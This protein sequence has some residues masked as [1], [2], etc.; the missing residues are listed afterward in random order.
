MKSHFSSI[1][2]S[3]GLSLFTKSFFSKERKI[4]RFKLAKA[5]MNNGT[6]QQS[7]KKTSTLVERRVWRESGEDKV[8]R[9]S[10]TK[11]RSKAKA[12]NEDPERKD[13]DSMERKGR[14]TWKV[15]LGDLAGRVIHQLFKATPY[16]SSK[17]QHSRSRI[18]KPKR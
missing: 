6:A 10:D 8:K 12:T 7:K 9:R 15:K 4:C 3:I 1:L 16:V 18:G 13:Q 5:T 11:G 2:L 14:G 17:E